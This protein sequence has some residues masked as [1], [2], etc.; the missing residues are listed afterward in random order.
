MV[1]TG[2]LC[3]VITSTD[4]NAILQSTNKEWMPLCVINNIT[5]NSF[6]VGLG[7]CIYGLTSGSLKFR[8][9]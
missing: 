1:V 4:K 2:F 7:H 3:C 9:V 8:D 6:G 5:Q